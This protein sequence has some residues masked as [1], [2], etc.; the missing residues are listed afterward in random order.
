MVIPTISKGAVDALSITSINTAK[1]STVYSSDNI[2]SLNKPGAAGR[3]GT[4]GASGRLLSMPGPAHTQQ[5]SP[6]TQPSPIRQAAP[7]PRPEPSQPQHPAPAC[8][9][10]PAAQAPVLPRGPLPHFSNPVRKGQK[11]LL[12]QAPIPRVKACFGW[13]VSNPDCDVDVSAFLL[14]AQK[15][16]LGDGWFVFYGQEASPD[17]SV[18]FSQADSPNGRE[19]IQVDFSKLNPLVKTIVF[20]LTINEAFEKRLN[21]SMVSDAYVRIINPAN[22]RELASYQMADYYPNVIS[23]MIGEL[24]IYNGA[25]KF[26]AVGNGVGRDLA[27]LCGLYGVQTV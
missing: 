21:F 16:V 12:S 15:K 17:N 6:T 13:N 22:N 18:L 1:I 11:I 2:T 4:A 10:G 24:Y 14:T 27:G 9:A 26:N 8:P 3:P 20:V 19:Q 5:A 7:T 25:W 23:M